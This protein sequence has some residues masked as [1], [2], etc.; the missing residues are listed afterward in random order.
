MYK[1]IILIL[2]IISIIFI[3]YNIYNNYY[4]IDK[5]DYKFSHLAYITKSPD[6]KQSMT[7]NIYKKNKESNIAYIEAIIYKLPDS[8]DNQRKTI[9][10]QEVESDSLKCV[11]EDGIVDNY[12]VDNFWINSET[13]SINGIQ[14]TINKDKYDYRRN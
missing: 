9:F 11:D 1:K 2:T 6:R 14:L 4:Y 5:T 3:A 10:W 13:V 8:K 7:I 12:C